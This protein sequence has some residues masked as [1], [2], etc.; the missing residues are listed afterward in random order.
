MT[1][2]K[3]TRTEAIRQRPGMYIGGTGSR[4]LNYMVEGALKYS[5]FTASL[6]LLDTVEM[7]LLDNNQIKIV[8]QLTAQAEIAGKHELST[9]ITRVVEQFESE[10]LWIWGWVDHMY[11]AAALSQTF[12]LAVWQDGIC[13]RQQFRQGVPVSE[14]SQ[15]P[16]QDRTYTNAVII[17]YQPDIDIFDK[18]AAVHFDILAGR[19]QELAFLQ[20]RIRIHLYDE[21]ES[22][23]REAFFQFPEGIISFLYQLNQAGYP[24][25]A[26]YPVNFVAGK[27]EQSLANG[28]S[29]GLLKVQFA[30]T[31]LF[32]WQAEHPST[33][34]FSY[35]N[36]DRTEA[37]GTHVRGLLEAFRDYILQRVDR[38][39]ELTIDDVKR[40]LV[41][42]IHV[43]HPDPQY[44]HSMRGE[45]INKDVYQAVHKA[46]TKALADFT[47]RYP[48]HA[49]RLMDRF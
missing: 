21:R 1:Y 45:F 24:S 7:T 39:D 17:S 14:A 43:E 19:L 23:T 28:P 11:V 38:E 40:G 10:T 31:S 46:V 25:Y 48:E 30:F 20:G 6:G 47:D 34:L 26:N 27:S 36:W 4:A 13:G 9:I 18:E 12:D 33:I 29:E 49:K 44:T 42:I 16:V 2:P 3:L 32:N 15:K 41:A 5:Y 37:G 35:V 8:N 22:P